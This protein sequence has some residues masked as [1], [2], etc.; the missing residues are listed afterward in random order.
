[1]QAA[2]PKITITEAEYKSLSTTNA[3]TLPTPTIE[4]VDIRL[5]QRH[6]APTTS[7]STWTFYTYSI[8]LTIEEGGRKVLEQEFETMCS[9]TAATTTT[10]H[11]P[12]DTPVYCNLDP[13]Q[14]EIVEK[15]AHLFDVRLGISYLRKSGKTCSVGAHATS[16]V[17]CSWGSG[18]YLRNQ[19]GHAQSVDCS[20]VG[21][22]AEE[23]LDECLMGDEEVWDVDVVEEG[24]AK[25]EWRDGL[26]VEIAFGNC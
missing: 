19:M 3:F 7:S 11:A 23:M 24:W 5:Q 26:E 1:M 6:V 25:A 17:S 13:W 14:P 9:F 2:F 20:D 12:T 16:R 21:V 8:L 10:A 18:I 22:F 15:T 4:E